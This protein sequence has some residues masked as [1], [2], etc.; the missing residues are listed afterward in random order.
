MDKDNIE[1]PHTPR[2][3]HALLVEDSEND[4]LLVVRTLRQGGYD[5]TYER[6]QTPEA[7]RAALDRETWDIV[8]ADYA[9]PQFSGL[10]ALQILQ[11][12]GLDMPFIVVS[13][14]IGETV[15]VSMMRAGAHDYLMKDNLARLAPAVQRELREAQERRA[16]RQVEAALRS[17]EE[18]FRRMAEGI[19]DGLTIVENG[20]VV[21]VNDRMCQILGR[22]RKELYGISGLDV[23]APEERERLQEIMAQS[24]RTGE[25][26][27][28]LEFWILRKDGTRRCIH[29]RYTARKSENGQ[30]DRYVVTT[31]I[32]QRKHMEE[33]LREREEL[34]SALVE[35]AYDGIVLIQDQKL[36]YANLRMAE[37]LG[38]YQPEEIWDTPFSR[39]IHPD[40]LAKVTDYYQRRMAGQ[41]VPSRYE[42]ALVG[43]DG[44]RID[45]ELNAGVITYR[46]QPTDFVFVRNITERKRAERLLEALN[47]AALAMEKA[48][49]PQEIF[50]AVEAAFNKLGL[51]CAVL[52]T[53]E[54]Q[55]HL[56]P[57][58]LSHKGAPSRLQK[59][60]PVYKPRRSPS[61]SKT[62]HCIARSFGSGKPCWSR[63]PARSWPNFCPVRSGPWPGN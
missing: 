2:Q 21:Y 1:K 48:L 38:N 44:K 14:T 12:S 54:R 43:K 11:E 26:P 24:Q 19:R 62:W 23:A 22:S 36:I 8:I 60:S 61:R 3:L 51:T 63:T 5:L 25:P 41:A 57:T 18:R 55:T 7:M 39:Y 49:T 6:V 20:Q 15:A 10:A 9:M 59:S 40:E 47:Q 37:I 33:A 17:S 53:N 16:R 4:A 58:Y 50:G 30:V 42:T 56:S 31:D 46:D 13:G 52:R 28:E 34:Y 29:N 32:T 27:Q 45:V 35:R